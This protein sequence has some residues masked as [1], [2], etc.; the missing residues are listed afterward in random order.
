MYLFRLIFPAIKGYA[1]INIFDFFC[2]EQNEVY[3]PIG[4]SIDFCI[5]MFDVD[6]Y[7]VK[8]QSLKLSLKVCFRKCN[9]K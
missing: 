5:L 3:V 6:Q 4:R 2:L 8:S 9:I 7:Q 1:R